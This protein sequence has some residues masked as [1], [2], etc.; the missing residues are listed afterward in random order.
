MRLRSRPPGT[1]SSSGNG[2]PRQRSSAV[3]EELCRASGIV[4]EQC[5]R[6]VE[7]PFELHGIG[8]RVET[9]ALCCRADDEPDGAQT[10]HVRR[11]RVAC[12]GGWFLTP[13]GGLER[14]PGDRP[15][16][17]ERQSG[18]DIALPAAAGCNQGR[19]VSNLQRTENA[20]QH[21]A[22]LRGR[23]GTFDW[24]SRPLAFVRLILRSTS[25]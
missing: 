9:V 21:R 7:V 3:A 1:W 14:E 17:V 12:R 2:R 8:R 19:A 25:M 10:E 24:S 20:D 16:R 22:I 18:E 6:A 11:D 13:C 5:S 15:A 23:A 4:L